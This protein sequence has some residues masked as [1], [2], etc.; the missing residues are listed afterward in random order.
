MLQDAVQG[1]VGGVVVLCSLFRIGF[2]LWSSS[3]SV[4]LY[5][6]FDHLWRWMPGGT[7]LVVNARGGTFVGQCPN[8]FGC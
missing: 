5:R 2:F 1:R 7:P 3:S 8:T 4:G 6:S